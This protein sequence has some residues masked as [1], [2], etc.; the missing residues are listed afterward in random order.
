MVKNISLPKEYQD[1][2][3]TALSNFVIMDGVVYDNNPIDEVL[4]QILVLQLFKPESAVMILDDDVEY[5]VSDYDDDDLVTSVPNDD[6]DCD[7]DYVLEHRV[8]VGPQ[9][10]E[11]LGR[12]AFDCVDYIRI[13]VSTRNKNILEKLK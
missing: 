11:Q 12:L 13:A 7:D 4:G 10:L 3:L 9:T 6:C 1:L 8:L 5:E 2:I